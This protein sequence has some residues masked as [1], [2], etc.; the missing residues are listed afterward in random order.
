MSPNERFILGLLIGAMLIS[1]PLMWN[2]ENLEAQ[3][4]D[5]QTEETPMFEYA[6]KMAPCQKV[7][8]R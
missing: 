7:S 4:V 6:E 3:I 5:L 8:R 2:I 1:I